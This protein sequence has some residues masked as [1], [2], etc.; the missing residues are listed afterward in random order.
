MRHTP[1]MPHVAIVS[2]A[3]SYR[4]GDHLAAARALGCAVTV[5]TD[6]A[7]AIPGAAIVV[8]F[9]DPERAA[10]TVLAAVDRPIDGVV[11]TDGAAV[12]VAGAVAR[13]LSLPAND[14]AAFAAAD[15]KLAQRQ[16]LA[17]AGVPQPDFTVVRAGDDADSDQAVALL[18]GVVKPVDRTASQ[19]VQRVDTPAQL[20]DG[21]DRV[22]GLVGATAPVLVERF[23][24]GM[25][26]AIDGLLQRGRLQVLTTF[27]KPDTPTG[28]T[29]PETLLISPARLPDVVLGSV[30]DV[31][32]RAARAIGL[33][34]GP[35]HAECKVDGDTVWFLELAARTIGGL[36][37]RSVQI[38]GMRVEELA[39][40]HA[41]RQSLPPPPRRGWDHSAGATGV[42]MLPVPARGRLVAVRG[43]ERAR[44]IS[45]VTDVVLSIGPGE[46]VVPLPDG[47]R[48]LGFVFARSMTADDCEHALRRAWGE[49]TVEIGS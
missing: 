19:G 25:E 26:V 11:G 3:G 33:A 38:A 28:P 16:A 29:F 31:V 2:P 23:V 32:A 46:P 49:L 47:D 22:R 14:A 6:A 44:S 35:I 4:V 39:I 27:D 1:P 48:Y 7:V 40:H 45:G 9:A 8:S 37:S 24:P 17:R 36:C 41:L 12:S 5:V 21:V 18:P 13:R 30:T 43:I 42:L 10:S 15:D 34:E 20:R